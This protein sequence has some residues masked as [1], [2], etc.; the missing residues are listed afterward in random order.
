MFYIA[1]ESD[2]QK[3]M[4]IWMSAVRLKQISKN[5]IWVWFQTT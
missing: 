1:W 5:V 2:K 3:A 4:H